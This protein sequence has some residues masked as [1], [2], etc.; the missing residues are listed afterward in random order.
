M[1]LEDT[2]R[3]VWS[4]ASRIYDGREHVAGRGD[5]REAERIRGILEDYLGE[6]LDL[7]ETPLVSWRLRGVDVWPTPSFVAVAPYVLDADVEARTFM[8]E[9]DPSDYRSWRGVPEG[10]IA[11]VI[12]PGNPDDLKYAV[13]HAWESGAHGVIVGSKVPRKIVATGSWGYSYTAGAPTPIPVV[14]VDEEAA[15]RAVW[16]GR[17]RIHV[18]ATLREE[19]GA[20][21]RAVSGGPGRVALTSHYDRWYTGFQDDILGIAQAAV[22][23]K[24]LGESR[25]VELLVFTGEEHGAPGP[26]GWY[27]AWGSRWLARQYRESGLAGSL[28]LVVNFDVAGTQPLVVSGAPQYTRG[29][30]ESLKALGV[31]AVERCCDCPECDGFSFHRAGVPSVSIH[32]LWNDKVRAIYHTPMDTP[33]KGD[34]LAAGAAVEAAV[35]T[36][37]GGPSWA[38]LEERL[39]EILYPGPLPARLLLHTVLGEARRRGWPLLYKWLSS[40]HLRPVLYGDYRYDTGG[41]IEAVF[42]PEAAGAVKL[43]AGAEIHAVIEPGAERL[44]YQAMPGSRIGEQA[45]ETLYGLLSRV[46][47]ELS[48]L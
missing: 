48:C 17:A 46:R 4:L 19:K 11:V 8:V 27:W 14:V 6:S 41:D 15:K 29:L 13:L 30:L 31:E 44:I 40:N 7:V 1:P 21:I 47:W 24:T 43:Q 2:V 34:P 35:R 37:S 39:V 28:E 20:T 10:S 18:S 38:S 5:W 36:A 22:A 9:G 23:Y 16:E 33:E 3:E 12:P 32:T 26:A 42:F 25:S 45:R